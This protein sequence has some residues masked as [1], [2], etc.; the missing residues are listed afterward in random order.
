MRKIGV[1]THPRPSA[2]SLR[3]R[4]FNEGKDPF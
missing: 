4:V 3:M 2:G 1:H